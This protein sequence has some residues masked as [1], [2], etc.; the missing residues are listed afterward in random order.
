MN[1]AYHYPI[2]YWNCACLSVDS[3][4]IDSND[5]Y[6]LI[7][8]DIIDI[9]DTEDK[10][11]QNKMDYAKIASALDKFKDSFKI[12]LPDINRSRLS[13]TPDSKTNSILYGLKGIS[14]I[15][16]VTIKEIVDNRPFVSFQDFLNRTSSKILTIDK[17]IN[18]IKSGAFDNIENKEREEILREFI[19]SR[20]DLKKRL[21]MQNA[22]MLIDMELLPQELAYESEV[23]KL[24]KELRRHRDSNKMWY[25]VDSLDI[26]SDKISTW[27]GIFQDSKIN[28][29][30]LVIDNEYGKYIDSRQWDNYYDTKMLNIKQYITKN[31]VE[32]LE[33]LNNKLFQAQWDKYCSGNRTQ[34]ELDS[35]N[36]YFGEHPLKNIGKELKI[37]LTPIKDIIEEASDGF[38]LI[39][40]KMIQKMKLYSIAGTVIDRDKTKGI[41]MIQTPDGVIPVK[42]YKDLYAIYAQ[43]VI[44]IDENGD[45]KV[46]E[47]SFFEKGV[48]ILVTGI[49]R[50]P[51]FIPKVY[52]STN[53]RSIMRIVL[54]NGHLKELV[55]KKGE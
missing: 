36:F 31:Q 20:S 24:T 16:D 47:E 50:G 51:T 38:F 32:L 11:I 42:C 10:K 39:Q 13:F 53:R 1:L 9:D 41:V 27:R 33:K 7:D 18:L 46:E 35:L 28:G 40:G 14:K 5:F 21:T 26:P 6:N 54:E 19:L 30:E 29:E 23:Y 37:E 4:A 17:I 15:T 52:K 43:N 55:D 2:I 34:W 22:N 48:H 8:E 12:N 25:K 3:S 44:S 45:K 49:K